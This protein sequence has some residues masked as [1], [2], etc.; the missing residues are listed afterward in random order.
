[1]AQSTRDFSLSRWSTSMG[2]GGDFADECRRLF[3]SGDLSQ[4]GD[5]GVY[6]GRTYQ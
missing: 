6:A 4:V 3:S 1:V 2:G 5:R